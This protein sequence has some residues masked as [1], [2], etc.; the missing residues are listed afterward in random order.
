MCGLA[1]S[2]KSLGRV[3]LPVSPFFRAAGPQ[4]AHVVFNARVDAEIRPDP[5]PEERRALLAALEL[6]ADGSPTAHASAWRAAAS[7]LDEDY[8]AT[9]RPPSRRGATRA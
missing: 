6:P 2:A 3:N 4:R 1:G 7:A 5:T 9:A 8:D